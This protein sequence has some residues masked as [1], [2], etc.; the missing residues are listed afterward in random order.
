MKL[1]SIFAVTVGAAT[2]WQEM[3]GSGVLARS[4]EGSPEALLIGGS[5]LMIAALLRHGL[6]PH[7]K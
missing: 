2:G 4:V 6:S 3:A 1:A 7:A 5:L